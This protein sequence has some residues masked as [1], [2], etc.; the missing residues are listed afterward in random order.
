MQNTYT[1]FHAVEERVRRYGAEK[2]HSAVLSISYSKVGPRIKKILSLAKEYGIPCNQTDS[3]R[4]DSMVR[5]LPKEAQD[6]R[7]IV[8]VAEGEKERAGNAV[9]LD[10]WLSACPQRA[11]VVMLDSVTDP[12]NVGAILR[13]CDQL[14]AALLVIP[15]RRSAG[16]VQDNE[17]IARS[18]AGASAYVPVAVVS[19]L[20]RAAEML[21]EAG[22]WIYGADMAG[23]PLQD[24]DFAPRS[25]LVMGSE[26]SGISQLLSKKCDSIVSIPTCGKIDSLNVSV[27]TGIILYE[28]RRKSL[29]GAQ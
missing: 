12:H 26:G 25:C 16:D 3:S 14:D 24:A 11:T 27:A 1:G 20:V 7:G 19:N 4:L 23:T 13:S 9:Q 6:H 8:L 22:F 29:T 18:S 15:E 2:K 10:Q 21:K 28:I 17:T 5:Q